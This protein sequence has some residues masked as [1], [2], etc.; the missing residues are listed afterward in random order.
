MQNNLLEF[1]IIVRKPLKC[2]WILQMKILGHPVDQLIQLLDSV[3]DVYQ[4]VTIYNFVFTH[5][6][7]V[8]AFNTSAD[9]L[10]TLCRFF[11]QNLLLKIC[12][13]W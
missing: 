11:F 4:N 12:E 7:V 3:G 10:F 9:H 1:S 5:Q 8:Y 6:S 13:K 2:T